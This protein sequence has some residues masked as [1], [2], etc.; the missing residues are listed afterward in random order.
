MLVLLPSEEPEI[1][2]LLS[3]EFSEELYEELSLLSEET[4]ETE[5]TAKTEEGIVLSASAIERRSAAACRIALLLCPFFIV[6]F[7]S[8]GYLPAGSKARA[9]L[10]S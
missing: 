2:G 8:F 4:P 9:A 6:S 7:L 5:L 1:S 10:F 3:D